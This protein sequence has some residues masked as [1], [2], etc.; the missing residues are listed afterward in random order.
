MSNKNQ[1]IFLLIIL[2]ISVVLRLLAAIYLGNQVEVLPGT[3]DQVSYHNLALRVLGGHGFTFGETWWPQTPAGEPTAHWSYLYTLYLI[4]IY[5]IFGV[6]P[7]VA[8][9]I[10]AMLVGILHPLIAYLL[11]KR[12]FNPAVGLLAAAFTA[13]YTYFIYY[14]ATLMTEPFYIAAIMASLYFGI[15]LVDYSTHQD[16][17]RR[18]KT[19]LIAAAIG[20]FLGI[21]IL[22]RQ[23][24][25]LFMPL[26][27]IWVWWSN[28]QKKNKSV[29]PQLFVSLLVILVL[30]LPFTAFNYSRFHRFVLL[31][32]NAGF[33]FFWA[34]HPVH[35]TNFYTLIPG[36][37]EAYRELIP[38]EYRHLD[39]AALDQSLLKEGLKF[40]VDDPVRYFKLSL[41]RIPDYFMFWPSSDS[42]TI[43]NISRVTSFGIFWPFMLAGVCLALYNTWKESKRH[44]WLARL[45]AFLA[46]PVSLL[47]A[48]ILAYSIIHILS[49]ALIRYRLPVDAVG[50]IFASYMVM[51]LARWVSMM[52]KKK[53]QPDQPLAAKVI[54]EDAPDKAIRG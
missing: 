35:G 4:G 6:N 30:I 24:F 18:N 8:R 43:S 36:G 17:S 54:I 41:S 40:I 38:A 13:V 2:A 33:A 50:L 42:G 16:F 19:F 10:Q 5:S 28:W 7:V 48:F 15:L 49:W 53:P 51:I 44:N 23:L 22:F 46:A 45:S 1:K 27:F 9:L 29:L 20:L 12:V 52:I 47:V 26:L 34:N 39:E 31:N 25:L 21:T 3:F 37:W 32:T 14:S 11:G